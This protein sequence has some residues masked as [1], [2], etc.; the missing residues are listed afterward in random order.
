[1]NAGASSRRALLAVL[2]AGLGAG[3]SE[4]AVAQPASGELLFCAEDE[5]SY[6]WLRR[7]GS[8]L[9]MLMVQ[10]VG[11]RV[12][13]AVR[14]ELLP[15]RRCLQSL[16]ENRVDG[17]FKASFKPERLKMGAYPMRGGLPDA[18]RAM[19]DESYH[20]YRLKGSS[21]QWDGQR[22]TGLDGRVG[23]QAGFSVVDVL[24]R[25][26][27]P[28]ESGTKSPETLLTMLQR[29][30]LGAVALQTSQGD[31]ELSR[32]PVL[33]AGIERV[34]PPLLSQPYYLLL[35]HALLQRDAALAERLWDAVAVV[36][37]SVEYRAA[38]LAARDVAGP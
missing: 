7:D 21:V 18:S 30:R 9:N 32:K 23:A 35:S 31:F 3:L 5:D 24:K 11:Q 28:T 22:V 16:Q 2:L 26:S 4:A 33:A 6:P 20:L 12:G 19:L 13:R 8:G 14:V 10:R 36:R 37:E 29:G 17:A 15:W 27:L 38:L 1:M 34:G 25:L